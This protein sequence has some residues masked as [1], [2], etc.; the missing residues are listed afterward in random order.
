MSQASTNRPL[1]TT[2]SWRPWLSAIALLALVAVVYWPATQADFIY[3]DTIDV[4]DNV[5]LRSL[6]GLSGIWFQ[7]GA[8]DQYYPLTYTTFWIEYHLWGLNWPGFHIVNLALHAGSVLLL[9]RLLA[10]LAVPGA[11]LAAAIFAVHPV[12]VETVAWVSERKNLLSC[13]LALASIW[14]YLRYAPPEP[15]TGAKPSPIRGSWP[16]YG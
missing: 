2:A 10:R 15:V 5:H 13:L 12:G 6:S 4:R 7:L 3:D 16:S 8:V 9:W 11:W 1:P 14:A